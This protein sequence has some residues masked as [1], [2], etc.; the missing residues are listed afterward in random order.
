MNKDRL[1]FSSR[2]LLTAVVFLYTTLAS[3]A[4]EE[5]LATVIVNGTQVIF[6]PVIPYSEVLVTLQGPSD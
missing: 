1:S 4:G 5:R 6:Q 3:A 2:V